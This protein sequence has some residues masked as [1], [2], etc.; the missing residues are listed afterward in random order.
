MTYSQRSAKK[1]N[2]TEALICLASQ[3]ETHAAACV[4][5]ALHCGARTHWTT[6]PGS[7]LIPPDDVPQIAIIRCA[8]SLRHGRQLCERI[9]SFVYH[10][11]L[12]TIIKQILERYQRNKEISGRTTPSRCQTLASPMDQRCVWLSDCRLCKGVVRMPSCVVD[13]AVGRP[14]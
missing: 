14:E 4:C 1:V 13:G 7:W 5:G 12:T 10:R 2:Q 6:L 8:C 3:M 9:A 11:G